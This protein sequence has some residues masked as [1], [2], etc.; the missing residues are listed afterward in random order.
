MMRD[1][2]AKLTQVKCRASELC[3][4][5]SLDKPNPERERGTLTPEGRML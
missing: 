4:E 1:G 2:P 5:L 3:L